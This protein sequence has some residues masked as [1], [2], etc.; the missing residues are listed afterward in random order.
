MPPRRGA[1]GRRT[2]PDQPT[3]MPP[4]P[5]EVEDEDVDVEH[6]EED[7]EDDE[8][9]LQS[10]PDSRQ[11]HAAGATLRELARVFR[12]CGTLEAAVTTALVADQQAEKKNKE[13]A[14]GDAELAALGTQRDQV[15]EELDRLIE[16]RRALQADISA[17]KRMMVELKK[18]LDDERRELERERVQATH[19][20]EAEHEGLLRDI[21]SAKAEFARVKANVAEYVRGMA[22]P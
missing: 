1:R 19:D 11:L 7:T 9:A 17:D 10:P 13:I 12:A 22:T 8:S 5:N 21:A 18:S 2:E 14:A 20:L 3:P 4:P 6:D 15:R 16:Q